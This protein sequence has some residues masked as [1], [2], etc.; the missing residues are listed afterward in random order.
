[1]NKQ[2]I[3]VLLLIVSAVMK[4]NA[5]VTIG[6]DS[7][8]V[9]T[10]DVVATKTDG[11]TAEGIVAPRL[12]RAQLN[13]KQSQYGAAQTGAFV[14]VTAIDGTAISNYSDQIRCEGYFY[15]NGT[16]WVGDCPE[17]RAYVDI[18]RH[19]K[20]FTFYELGTETEDALVVTA[21]GSS[22]LSYQW[23]I[24]TGNNVHV[25]VSRA[26]TATDGSGF[27]THS[28]TPNVTKGTTL[29]A[30]NTG[31]TRYY[32][33]VT[34]ETGEFKE[35]DIAEVAVGCGAK[36]LSGGWISFMCFNLGATRHAIADQQNIDLTFMEPNN[37]SSTHKMTSGEDALYGDLFQ[38]GR[39]ADGHEKR[40]KIPHG[41]DGSS[42]STDNVV[43][44]SDPTY[45]DGPQADNV[46]EY[47]YQQV[48]R[49]TS[50]YGK[51]I[52]TAA[53]SNY[54]WYGGSKALA[55]AVDMLWRESL[56]APNDPCIKMMADGNY[57]PWYPTGTIPEN[58]EGTTAGWRLPQI[59]EWS[60]IFR[61]EGSGIY[62]D[63]MA[64]T[65]RWYQKST[66]STEGV[67]GVMIQPDGVT[68]TLFLPAAGFRLNNGRLSN[69][70]VAGYYWTS[71]V[72][73]VN[74]QYLRFSAT[75]AYPTGNTFRGYGF[76]LRCIKK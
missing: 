48:S 51:F 49:G 4:M 2:M 24:I 31:F 12:T 56:F 65:W 57:S 70:A 11:T 14:Y 25:R 19:P 18:T 42:N 64:N 63:A 32:C 46:Y 67:K 23:H 16:Y 15:F 28:F 38:W 33:V 50:H 35:T 55:I 1:M 61:A 10:L 53:G 76:S 59:G 26:C 3:L 72:S 54:N 6:N 73:G 9:L 29:N 39:I 7:S 13:A 21:R 71:T 20:S 40:N 44:W 41:N 58:G 62:E 52:K 68:T 60:A 22:A 69:T 47:P 27:D 74:A 8:P 66:A 5:Q 37:S 43:S 45:E 30:T 36:N 34:N 17:D 75:S